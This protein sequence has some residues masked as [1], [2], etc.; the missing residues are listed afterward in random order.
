MI[1]SGSVWY[2]S[3]LSF[4]IFNTLSGADDCKIFKLIGIS[5]LSLGISGLRNDVHTAV[6]SSLPPFFLISQYTMAKKG[7]KS[8]P[9]TN[10][11]DKRQI[12]GTFA[13]SLAGDFLPYI[14]A[15]LID[16]ISFLKSFILLIRKTI[17]LMKR[18]A[19]SLLIRY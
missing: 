7:E 3:T 17:G 13:V 10:V 5:K 2:V 4:I 16:V 11:S 8:V 19:K 18:N 9:I 6:L 1:S 12:T 14:K 15:R